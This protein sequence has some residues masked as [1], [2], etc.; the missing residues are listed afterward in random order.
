MKELNTILFK[1]L[2]D[3]KLDKLKREVVTLHTHQGGL[4]MINIEHFITSLK[5]T[6]IRRLIQSENSPTKSL[7]E[8]TITHMDNLFVFGYQYIES[9]IKY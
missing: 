5:I 6:W 8:N 9:N 1:F 7:F 3:D 4:N 2:W